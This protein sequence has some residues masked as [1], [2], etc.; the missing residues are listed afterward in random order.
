MICT[1]LGIFRN[2][3]PRLAY[4]RSRFYADALKEDVWV[5]SRIQVTGLG[6]GRSALKSSDCRRCDK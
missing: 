2:A 6:V 3:A 5:L 4:L 1:K